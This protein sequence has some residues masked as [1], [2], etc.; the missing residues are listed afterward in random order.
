MVRRKKLRADPRLGA[1]LAGNVRALHSLSLAVDGLI[2]CDAERKVIAA[3]VTRGFFRAAEDEQLKNY[4]ARL[5]S[6]RAGLWEVIHEVGLPL[7]GQPTAARSTDEWRCFLIG[8]SAACRLVRL[9]RL[10]VDDLATDSLTQ[11]KLNEAAPELR[12]ERKQFTAIFES[13]ADPANALAIDEAMRFAASKRRRIAHLRRDPVVGWAAEELSRWEAALDPSKRRFIK[14]LWDFARHS[15]RRRAA[16]ALQ[17]L[18]FA[19]M[20]GA[21]RVIAELRD[22]LAEL[23]VGEE[24]G[25]QLAELLR[26]GDVLVTRRERVASN[27]LL[28][29]YWPHSA[30]F[31]GS[32]SDRERLGIEV[33]EERAGR[34][35]GDVAILEA[36]KDGVLFRPLSYTLGVDAVAVIRPRLSSLEIARGI[37]RAVAHEGKMYNFDFDFFRS[38]RLVC[39]EV[40]YRAFDGLGDLEIPLRERSGR[41]TL[42]A[43]DLLELALDGRGFETVAVYGHAACGG[44]L[45]VGDE[46]ARVLAESLGID[47][48]TR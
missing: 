42:S 13:L 40:V 15:L 23:S 45:K 32:R 11:R 20:E 14:R 10:L 36:Q 17:K 39:T 48:K 18:Q 31:V 24:V 12:I 29:G 3:G 41:P 16:S 30:L 7:G 2:Q 27:L 21:G 33:D 25:E 46:A 1:I 37:E 47:R 8:Y 28:P 4:L 38:D 35:Q 22:P 26:P 19:A 34:W 9:D 6:V 44:Q 43:E 5:L